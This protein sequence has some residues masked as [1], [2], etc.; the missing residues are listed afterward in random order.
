MREMRNAIR[1]LMVKPSGKL[2]VGTQ[3]DRR[4]WE[5]ISKSLRGKVCDGG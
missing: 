3:E 2:P 5:D 4:R 1:F